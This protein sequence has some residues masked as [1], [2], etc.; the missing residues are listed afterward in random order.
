MM[1]VRNMVPLPH[2]WVHVDQAPYAGKMQSTGHAWL[3][4]LRVSSRYGHT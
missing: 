4:Q 2:D 3:L 1:R